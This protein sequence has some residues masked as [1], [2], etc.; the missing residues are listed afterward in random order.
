MPLSLILNNVGAKMG[1]N[2]SIPTQRSVLLRFVNEAA[3]ELYRQSDMIGV[4]MEQVFK[5]NGDQTVA[6]PS[7]VGPI[8]AIREFN[9]QIPWSISRLRPRYNQANWTD[10][11][12]NFRLK[13]RQPLA[14]A[15]V[16]QAQLVVTVTTEQPAV[17]VSITGRTLE[18]SNIT[19]V[20]TLTNL[21]NT[22]V[23]AF[24]EVFSIS[25]SGVTVCD[26]TINDIDGN[27]LAA[28]PNNELN[29][30]YEIVDVSTL[31]WFNQDSGQA[32]HFVEILYKKKL[33]YLS[34]DG[35]DF[36]AKGYEY[37]IINK[38]LQLWCEEQGKVEEALAYDQKASRTL[39]RIN[40]D[41]N[42]AT[43]DIV[44]MVAHPH[45]QLLV[46]IRTPRPS[47]YRGYMYPYG[48][49]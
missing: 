25:K 17:T 31:P 40:E 35:D 45:D 28:I 49:R 38:V 11:W 18:A 34:E 8:R 24:V 5:V 32:E 14:R 42:R 33:P 30:E 26:V 12:R 9:T 44:A 47:R 36:P 13:G 29:A 39:T 19:E 16:N 23:N 48:L 6:L 3:A 1:Y 43:E 10:M 4:L 2:P 20:V 7:Y 46:K 37:V 22:T 21:A 15:I 27:V 41:E